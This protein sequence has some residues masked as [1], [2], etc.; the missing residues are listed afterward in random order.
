MLN[1]EIVK[2][3]VKG[4]YAEEKKAEEALRKSEEKFR[5]IFE[6][7][8]DCMI[9]VDKSG[10]ILDVN[11]KAVEVFGSSIEELL[12]R[13]IARVMV[14][15]VSPKDIPMVMNAFLEGIAGR[16]PRIEVS[17][18]NRKG[19]VM[20]LDCTNS[21]LKIDGKYYGLLVVARDVSEHKRIENALRESEEKHRSLFELAP[22]GIITSDLKGNITSVNKAFLRITGFSKEEI[23]GKHFTKLPTIREMDI[24][25]YVKPFFSFLRGK[26]IGAFEFVYRR[27]DGTLAWGEAHPSV[28]KEQGK[29]TGFQ[30]VL[31]DIT[32]RKKAEDALRKSEGKYRTLLENVPQKIFLKDMNS[33][34]V[35]CNENYARDLKIKSDE[36]TGK[37]DYDFYPKE[38]AEKYRAD[39]RRIMESGETEDIEEDYIQDGQKV[40]VHT[41]KTP[42]K[43]EKGNVVGI[44]GIFWDI[45]EQKQME[46]KLRQYSEH[47]EE[48]VKERTKELLESEKRYSVVVE[49]ASDGVVMIQDGKKCIRKQESP[50]NYRLLKRRTDQ[51]YTRKN[52]RPKISPTYKKR[53]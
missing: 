19:Q 16:K 50:R 2:S 9:L 10:R 48:L 23:V 33:V 30:A 52:N 49:G 6:S 41:V 7:A 38:L 46:E 39:D 13:H 44:L 12:G 22:D 53:I 20:H 26:K 14:G 3:S 18:K 24:A 15:L 31:R 40:F 37:T 5:T 51:S 43:D 11:K 47:L 32:E 42:V 8:T 4:V 21:L 45:T 35:S 36:I 25:K 28:L 27:K 1:D 29:V 34:Y 17:L